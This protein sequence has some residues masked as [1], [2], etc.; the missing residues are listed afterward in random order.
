VEH[1]I[2]DQKKEWVVLHSQVLTLQV[3]KIGL[4]MGPVFYYNA[5]GREIKGGKD[6]WNMFFKRTMLYTGLQETL[7]VP[8]GSSDLR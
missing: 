3:C 1:D 6:F 7:S 4:P 2:L 8:A 5:P